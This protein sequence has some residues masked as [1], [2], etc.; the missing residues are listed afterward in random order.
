MRSHALLVLAMLAVTLAIPVSADTVAP[1]AMGNAAVGGARL[2]QYT[3]GVEGGTGPNNI[4]LLIKTWGKVNY[5]DTTN[6]YFYID[7]GTGRLDGSG[8]KGIR[9]S[10]AN[11]AQGQNVTPPQTSHYVVVTGVVSTVMISAKVQPCLRVR[12]QNDVRDLGVH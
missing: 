2:N 5:V 10:Y 11:L 8:N 6:K 9:V 7:D 12:G 1:R 4:G 3:P